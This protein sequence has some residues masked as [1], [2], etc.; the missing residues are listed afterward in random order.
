MKFLILKEVLNVA[1]W[2]QFPLVRLLKLH[3]FLETVSET[4]YWSTSFGNGTGGPFLIQNNYQQ[5]TLLQ[6]NTNWIICAIQNSGPIFCFT[7]SRNFRW[8]FHWLWKICFWVGAKRF[9]PNLF[10]LV[11]IWKMFFFGCRLACEER[12]F[13]YYNELPSPCRESMAK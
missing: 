2:F 1:F 5:H 3:Q 8:K 10:T 11:K 9:L 13:C 12:E 4:S 6:R 7:I